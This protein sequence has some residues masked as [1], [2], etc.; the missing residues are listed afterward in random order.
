[1]SPTD[2]PM[3]SLLSPTQPIRSIDERRPQTVARRTGERDPGANAPA[4]R[5]RVRDCVRDGS[6]IEREGRVLP[7]GQVRDQSPLASDVG[8]AAGARFGRT[9]EPLGAPERR[10]DEVTCAFFCF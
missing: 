3:R 2:G 8:V 9:L 5:Q 1:M 7:D 6:R 4:A 10:R